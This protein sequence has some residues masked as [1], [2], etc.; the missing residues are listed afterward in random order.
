M[1]G[2][3]RSVCLVKIKL[4]SVNIRASQKNQCFQKPSPNCEIGSVALLLHFDKVLALSKF[5]LLKYEIE[6]NP[7]A[8]ILRA[9]S[10]VQFQFAQCWWPRESVL[11]GLLHFRTLKVRILKVITLSQDA[12]VKQRYLC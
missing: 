7:I 8:R 1:Y 9:T 11:R 4:A 6:V 3:Y 12:K 10:T 2:K 5:A